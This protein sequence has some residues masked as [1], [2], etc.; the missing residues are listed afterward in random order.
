MDKHSKRSASIFR[1]PVLIAFTLFF[2]GLFLLDLVTPDRAYSELENTTLSQRPSLSSVSADGL[3]KF[4]TAYTKYVKDQVAGRDNWVALQS[5]VETKVMQKEQ[6][7]GILL[8][9]EHRM[10]ARRYRVLPTEERVWNKNLAAVQSLGERYPGKVSFMLVPSASVLY[11][12]DLPLAAPQMDEEGR[13]DEAQA[14]LPAVQF[15]RVTDAL[16]AHKDE[17]LYYRTDHHWTTLG[18]YYA[19]EQF[20]EAQGLTPFDRSAHSVETAENFYGTHYSKAR[21]WNAEPDTITWYDLQ[22]RLTIW[23]V[24]APGQPT[25]GTQTGLYDTGKLDVYDKYAMF[26]HGNNGLSRVEGDGTGKILV[27]KDSYANSFVPYLTANYAAIDVVDF[28]NY[29]YGLDQLIADNDYDAILVLYSYSSFTSD[30]YLYRA[31]VAG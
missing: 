22:N 19:Y 25:E 30:P 5:T 18:A 1:Y 15:L 13:I 11:P 29:N 7:G 9:R 16:R 2:A 4:F 17:Y 27:I 24:T 6:S 14:A 20:C 12:E 28:R 21:T 3:N 10:F 26:L 23:N 31:G 8:G